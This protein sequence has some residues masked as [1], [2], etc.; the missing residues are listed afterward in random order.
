M[1]ED[2]S[3]D[4][5]GPL[6]NSELGLARDLAL[7]T[8]LLSTQTRSRLSKRCKAATPSAIGISES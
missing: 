4:A 8:D 1:R 7:R 5:R 6:G 3:F 2:G